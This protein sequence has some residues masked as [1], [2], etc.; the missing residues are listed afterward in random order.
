MGG[1]PHG[2]LLQD[3]TSQQS[4]RTQSLDLGFT[5]YFFLED[6]L[7]CSLSPKEQ[8]KS[9]HINYLEPISLLTGNAAKEP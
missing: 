1:Q 5:I 7:A 6:N 4:T 3:I 8:W 9:S 2:K